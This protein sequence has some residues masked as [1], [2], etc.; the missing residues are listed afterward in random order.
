VTGAHAVVTWVARLGTNPACDGGQPFDLR[1]HHL[2]RQ[3]R[4][5]AIDTFMM[6]VNVDVRVRVSMQ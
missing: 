6:H 1:L 3:F 5:P 2:G 4:A